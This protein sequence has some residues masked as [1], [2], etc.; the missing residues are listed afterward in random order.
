MDPE[1]RD[2][3]ISVLS[4]LLTSIVENNNAK[5][6]A[7]E[8]QSYSFNVKKIPAIS[9]Q[10]YLERIARYAPCGGQCFVLSLVYLDRLIENNKNFV[11]SS[12]NVHRLLITSIMLASKFYEDKYMD[13]AFYARVGGIP[14]SE[15]NQLE[16]DFVFLIHFE[17]TVE[18]EVF[19]RYR[20][21]LLTPN[22]MKQIASVDGAPLVLSS[23]CSNEFNE[24]RRSGI[25][26][27]VSATYQNWDDSDDITKHRHDD[28]LRSNVVAAGGSNESW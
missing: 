24:K 5:S 19:D 12:R 9:I 3:V 8:L 15:L 18:P 21:Q 23:S 22:L 6:N 28:R 16:V 1:A 26:S 10:G 17:L 11:I 7:L 27:A 25:Y 2:S 20:S 13:N 14:V 4:F